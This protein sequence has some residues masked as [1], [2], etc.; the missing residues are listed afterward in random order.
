MAVN[1]SDVVT[2]RIDPQV[3][4]TPLNTD[5]DGYAH[6]MHSSINSGPLEYLPA[7]F[8]VFPALGD[9]GDLGGG[10]G[11]ATYALD[12][13]SNMRSGACVGGGESPWRSLMT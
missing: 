2:G 6:A 5:V 12:R 3:L 13:L 11:A 8:S 4:H 1:S 10:V 9:V 7:T